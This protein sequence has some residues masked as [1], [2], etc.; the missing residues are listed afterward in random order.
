MNERVKERKDPVQRYFENQ[1]TLAG[2]EGEEVARFTIGL[3]VLF[4][5]SDD[6]APS[7]RIAEIN[8][9]NSGNEMA[10]NKGTANDRLKDLFLKI[11][12]TLDDDSAE[13]AFSGKSIHALGIFSG[14]GLAEK[15][16]QLVF[17]RFRVKR[18]WAKI[19]SEWNN[20][21]AEKSRQKKYGLDPGMYKAFREF[22]RLQTLHEFDR[23]EE[24]RRNTVPVDFRA[25]RHVHE[26][27]LREHVMQHGHKN[28]IMLE[29]IF[30]NKL[31]MRRTI[32]PKYRPR[33]WN[34]RTFESPTGFWIVKP[35]ESARQKGI[36]VLS[37]EQLKQRMKSNPGAFEKFVVQ[38][39]EKTEKPDNAPA[40]LSGNNAFMRLRLDLIYRRAGK[41][42]NMQITYG[43]AVMCVFGRKSNKTSKPAFAN[44]D[45]AGEARYFRP[46]KRELDTALAA[47][48]A[49]MERIADEYDRML[50]I[51]DEWSTVQKT[52]APAR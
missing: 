48:N 20:A 32:D 35:R 52:E 31:L 38:V 30:E 43:D 46:T 19:F 8:G 41:S 27:W 6:G 2:I 50:A 16:S 49:S 3:D 15:T 26:E 36:L 51:D 22:L 23:W 11:R 14:G 1:N 37:N 40:E 45:F 42:R 28:F 18:D 29:H 5:K 33:E 7:V 9:H 44:I 13:D 17:D 34:R 4:C 10:D 21:L 47:A 25:L 24:S 39:L 12:N